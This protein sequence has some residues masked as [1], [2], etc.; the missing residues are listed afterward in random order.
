MAYENYKSFRVPR[1]KLDALY[2]EAHRL[3]AK[4][5]RRLKYEE[6]VSAALSVGL[7]HIDE[8]ELFLRNQEAHIDR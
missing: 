7:R 3:T 2:N 6:V 4:L 1:E 8:L 5:N